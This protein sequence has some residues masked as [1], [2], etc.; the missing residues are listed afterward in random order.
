M[1]VEVAVPIVWSAVHGVVDLAGCGALPVDED[2]L[3]ALHEQAMVTVHRGI[4]L[5]PGLAAPQ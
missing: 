2:T 3:E 4:T 5:A 1:P